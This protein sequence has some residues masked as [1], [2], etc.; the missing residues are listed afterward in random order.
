MASS[1]LLSPLAKVSIDVGPVV[2]FFAFYRLFGIY[3]AAVAVGIA[4]VVAV[5]AS[6]RF[7]GKVS[8]ALLL[9]AGYGAALR[10]PDAGARR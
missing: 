5:T 2:V 3:E 6:W 7:T 1:R 10:Y 8:V 4:A 9:S